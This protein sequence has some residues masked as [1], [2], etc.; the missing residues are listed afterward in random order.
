MITQLGANR[1]I[2][3]G[4][5]PDWKIVHV[6]SSDAQRLDTITSRYVLRFGRQ[7]PLASPHGRKFKLA[8]RTSDGWFRKFIG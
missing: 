7:E 8:V 2:E 3:W 4:K 6:A 5:E 1:N